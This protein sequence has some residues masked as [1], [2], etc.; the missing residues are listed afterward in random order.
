MDIEAHQ[1]GDIDEFKRRIRVE[2]NAKQR[3][4]YRAAVLAIEGMETRAIIQALGRSRGFVQRWAYVYR[5]HGIDAIAPKPPPG[6]RPKLA[7]DHVP[8]FKARFEAGPTAADGG[9]CT[10]RAKDVA[11]KNLKVPDNITLL[12]L[13]PYSPELN[14]VERLWAYVKSHYL[15]NRVFKDYDELMGQSTDAWNKITPDLLRSICNCS[16]LTHENQA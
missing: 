11:R 10:L 16:W 3:D 2:P 13:P 1:P 8:A 7:A 15:A 9:V 14:P 12:P 6:A 4:R 5:D